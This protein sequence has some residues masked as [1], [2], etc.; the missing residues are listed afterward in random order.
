MSFDDTKKKY[1][2]A[3]GKPDNSKKGGVDE[4]AW[5]L[6]NTINKHPDLYTTSS[7]SGRTSLLREA[8]SGRKDEAHWYFVSHEECSVKEIISSIKIA[9]GTVWF[10]FEG[11]IFHVVARNEEIA[12]QFLQMAREA[13]FKHSGLLA[14]KKRYIIEIFDA[15]RLEVPIVIDDQLIVPETFIEYLVREANKKLL[16]THERILRLKEK[17]KEK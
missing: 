1:L 4:L 12:N 3:L 9:Q 10:K 17:I 15:E 8:A 13:G 14:T 6:I 7:C 11:A 2:L 16:V 5:P